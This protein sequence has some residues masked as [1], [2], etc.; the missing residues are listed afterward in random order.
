M[1]S[2]F[3]PSA[4]LMTDNR[5]SGEGLHEV[6]IRNCPHCQNDVMLNPLRTRPRNWCMKCDAYICDN[7]VAFECTPMKK[8]IDDAVDARAK[9]RKLILP[10]RFNT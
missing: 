6:D 7:C 1:K 5:A 10:D 2:K 3:R 9:G 8:I 4:Y